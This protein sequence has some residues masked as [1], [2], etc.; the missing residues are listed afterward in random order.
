MGIPSLTSQDLAADSRPA[1][2]GGF[3]DRPRLPISPNA[4]FFLVHYAGEGGSWEIASDGL[5]GPTWLP[6]IQPFPIRPGAAGVRTVTA[7]EPR[8]RMWARAVQQIEEKGGIV[9]PF[10]LAVSGEHLPEGVAAG[11]YLRET[12]CVGG[13]YYHEAWD[14]PRKGV[15]GNTVRHDTDRA[16]RNRWRASLVASGVIPAPDPAVLGDARTRAARRVDVAIRDASIPA[17]ARAEAVAAAKA[18]AEAMAAADV[19][20]KPSKA[21][22]APKAAQ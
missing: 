16:A 15:R 5:P 14:R 4:P 10:D 12:D 19:P 9:L 6:V 3:V 11:S 21:P 2:L 18:R 7:G 22:K 20:G 17:D 1:S 13:T 8:S